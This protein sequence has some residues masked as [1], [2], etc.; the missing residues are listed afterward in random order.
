MANKKI[1]TVVRWSPLDIPKIIR[2]HYRAKVPVNF[3][4]EPST[5]KSEGTLQAAKQL[6][7]EEGREFFEWNRG[8]MEQKKKVIANPEK[9]FVFADLRASETDIGELRL[10]D[11]KNGEEFISF[12][13][14]IL[15]AAMSSDTARGI[16]FFDEMNLAPNMIKAQFYKII[17]DKAI[18]D[19]PISSSVLCVSAG[20][21]AE[22]S[23]GVTEDP[24]PLVLRRGNYHLRPLKAEEYV[25]YAAGA[26]HHKY[27]IGYLGFQPQDAHNIA[28]DLPDSVG[29]PCPRTWTKQSDILNANPKM[30]LMDIEMTAT[31]MLGQGVAKKFAAFV[32]SAQNIDLKNILENPNMIEKYEKDEDVS[33][34]YAIMSGVVDEFKNTKKRDEVLTAICKI[35]LYFK[36]SE[37]G[38][39]MLRNAKLAVG[40]EGFEKAVIQ[41]D[42]KIF[43]KVS[44]RYGKYVTGD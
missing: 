17:N 18:G 24:V 29:Q 2:A 16:L 27:V 39:F 12:K 43:T 4:A 6:A 1:D 10:Q 32:K 23:R 19:I 7:E 3:I 20:N 22:H 5:V 28:Y 34:I 40:K 31:G 42:D 26:N 44:D 14:N 9:Y 38:A 13:Y 30:S 21:E 41:M 37:Y 11:L 33:L 15:F 8:S 36:R 35:A 25:E